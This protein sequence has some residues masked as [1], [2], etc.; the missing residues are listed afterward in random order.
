MTFTTT[1]EDAEC[2]PSAVL[3]QARSLRS[4][5]HMGMSLNKSCRQ[6]WWPTSLAI[7]LIGIYNLS[8]HQKKCPHAKNPSKILQ[9]C[10]TEMHFCRSKHLTWNRKNWAS[11]QPAPKV[12][13]NFIYNINSPDCYFIL[14]SYCYGCTNNFIKN[15]WLVLHQWL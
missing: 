15:E 3:W 10:N 13:Y 9:S 4:G 8:L 6:L 5:K 11:Q 7:L 12:F 14:Q 2:V 1:T